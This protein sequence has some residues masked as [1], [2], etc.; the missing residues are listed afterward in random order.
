M[1]SLTIFLALTAAT[2]ALPGTAQSK[3]VRHNPRG[4]PN[5]PELLARLAL[6]GELRSAGMKALKNGNFTSAE[7]DFRRSIEADSLSPSYYGL[8][9]ALAGQGRTAEAIEAYRARIYGPPYTVSVLTDIPVHG[10]INPDVRECPGA[11]GAEAWMQYALLLSQTGQSEEAVIVYTKALPQVP[12]VD[13]TTIHRFPDA[14]TL[15]PTEFQA[16]VHV[17]LGLC[18]SF[19]MDTFEENAAR[20]MR[21]YNAARQIQPES[22]LTNYYYGY[23]WQRLS[24]PE[25]SRFG[26]EQQAK[27]AL[28]K[29]VKV[30]KGDVKKAAQKALM[31]AMNPGP[32]AK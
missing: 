10:L 15:T 2:L 4:F 18:A 16:S 13:E 24:P 5:S 12:A 31:V 11:A 23:G 29:A 28:L 32:P 17:A 19:G 8:G 26:T 22:A 9:Q 6:E 7:A 27:A 3:A 14:A 20:A 21:E 25:R 1:K 30:G